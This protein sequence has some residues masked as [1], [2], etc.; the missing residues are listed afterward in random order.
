MAATGAT[1]QVWDEMR[2][3][4]A[5]TRYDETHQVTDLRLL[6]A[7]DD[8]APALEIARCSRHRFGPGPCP[9]RAN[10]FEPPAPGPLDDRGACRQL[11][12][13]PSGLPGLTRI[14]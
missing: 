8:G 2:C 6:G 3:P 11:L 5:F 4:E 1:P 13:R 7:S 9:R 10:G 12:L 14:H